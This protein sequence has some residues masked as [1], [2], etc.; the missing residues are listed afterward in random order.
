MTNEVGTLL[1]SVLGRLKEYT[2]PML[3]CSAAFLLFSPN[4]ASF[5]GFDDAKLPGVYMLAAWALFFISIASLI[6]KIV[7]SLF[8]YVKQVKASISKN[9]NSKLQLQRK[10]ESLQWLNKNESEILFECLQNNEQTFCRMQANTAAIS[11]QQKGIVDS[12]IYGD[13]LNTSFTISYD[14]WS[15]LVLDRDYWLNQLSKKEPKKQMKRKR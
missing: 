2:F 11:L 4:I 6:Q 7:T 15:K 12:K 1:N 8:G 9:K 10:L 3:V 5:A 13:V 14:V